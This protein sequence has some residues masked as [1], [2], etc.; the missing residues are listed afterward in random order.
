MSVNLETDMNTTSKDS[1]MDDEINFQEIF[2]SIVRRWKWLSGGIFIGLGIGVFQLITTKPLYEGEFQIVIGE[3]AGQGAQ[4]AL[5]AQNPGLA[6]VVNMGGSGIKDSLETEVQILYS[7]SVLRPIFEAVKEKK[8]NSNGIIFKHWVRKSI[9]VSPKR[10]TTVLTVKFKDEDKTLIKPITQLISDTYQSYSNQGRNR[11]IDSVIEYLEAQIAKIKPIAKESAKKA[12]DFGL[13][14][15]LSA[16]DGLPIA[17]TVTGAESNTNFGGKSFIDASSGAITKIGGSRETAKSFAKAKVIALELLLKEAEKEENA[18]L[19]INPISEFLQ[20]EGTP[21]I[22]DEIIKIE[23]EIAEKRSRFH[24]GDPILAKLIR[25]RKEL[26]YVG[27]QQIKSRILGQLNVAKSSLAALDVSTEILSKHRELTQKSLRDSSTLVNLQNQLASYQ[28]EKARAADPWKLIS[29]P[30]VQDQP[31]SPRKL[32]IIAISLMAGFCLGSI[33]A[34]IVDYKS[35][36]IFSEKE[37]IKKMPLRFLNKLQVSRME[38]WKETLTLIRDNILKN[39]SNIGLISVGNIDEK[40]IKMITDE[41]NKII[42]PKSLISSKSLI[43]MNKCDVQIAI[44]STGLIKR[45]DLDYFQG[46]INIQNKNISGWLLIS[47]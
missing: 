36:I 32:R 21:D 38:E 33:S 42:A 10:N 18:T 47:S 7:P 43:E 24:P 29:S 39:S 6:S 17:G 40:T 14:N 35:N 27:N 20:K 15:N 44:A 9:S 19:F 28:L 37:L 31:I 5:L 4:A 13:K 25:Q 34:L 8:P 11:E 23:T 41:F 3:T 45:S 22:T 12:L 16:M 1:S 46:Q 26:L 2:Y 30:T